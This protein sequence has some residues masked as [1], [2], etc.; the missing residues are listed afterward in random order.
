MTPPGQRL[1]AGIESEGLSTCTSPGI[2]KYSMYRC[3]AKAVAKA[4]KPSIGQAQD[5]KDG[6]AAAD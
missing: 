2:P 5:K 3:M 4:H 1:Q 6:A